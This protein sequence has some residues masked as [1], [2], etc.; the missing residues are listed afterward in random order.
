[1][2]VR[3]T[4]RL[5]QVSIRSFRQLYSA[6]R[7]QIQI[8]TEQMRYRWDQMLLPA[9]YYQSLPH[10]IV[11]ETMVLDRRVSGQN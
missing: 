6:S 10:T 7:G 5:K 8:V 2:E 9:C 11:V 4:A 1:M 3:I